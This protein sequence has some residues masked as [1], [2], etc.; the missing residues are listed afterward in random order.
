MAHKAQGGEADLSAAASRN[1]WISDPVLW[2]SDPVDGCDHE[3]ARSNFE[4]RSDG[5][6]LDR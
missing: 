1:L 3:V 6:L 4:E 5:D 2:I